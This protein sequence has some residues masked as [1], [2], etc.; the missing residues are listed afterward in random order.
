MSLQRV[1]SVHSS[2]PCNCQLAIQ[3]AGCCI[4]S[5]FMIIHSPDFQ[6]PTSILSPS[7]SIQQ[8]SASTIHSVSRIFH[9]SCLQSVA[10]ILS[11]GTTSY[12]V[13]AIQH[14]SCPQCLNICP[15]PIC[16][17]CPASVRLHFATSIM[18]PGSKIRP[19][20]KTLYRFANRGSSKHG[21]QWY[22]IYRISGRKYK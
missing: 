12:V 7:S 16:P 2:G 4:T 20:S 11:P 9:L 21:C 18:H 14:A 22:S 15:T 3:S 19:V 10:S 13:S 1:P 17:Q 8:P 6:C 5:V